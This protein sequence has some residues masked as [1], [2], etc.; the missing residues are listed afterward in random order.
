MRYYDEH[1]RAYTLTGEFRV[2]APGEAVLYHNT[3][4][5]DARGR[6][7]GTVPC[8][9]VRPCV[10]GRTYA[11][12]VA[13]ANELIRRDGHRRPPIPADAEQFFTGYGYARPAAVLWWEWSTT[14]GTWGALVRWDDGSEVYTY[15]KPRYDRPTP[16]V[17]FDQA[18]P[19]T[20]PHADADP[21]VRCEMCGDDRDTRWSPQGA[22]LCRA[23]WF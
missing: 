19:Y 17:P 11:D 5:V 10:L 8:H 20:P 2:P 1:G 4:A 21:A 14:F 3:F 6:G 12:E 22:W 13:E 18:E 23:H 15:P 16:A 9:I 7:G